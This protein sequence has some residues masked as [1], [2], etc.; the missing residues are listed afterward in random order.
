[1]NANSDE[2]VKLS[3]LLL[4]AD[5]WG[6]A[7]GFSVKLC[8]VASD[9]LLKRRG[10]PR[11]ANDDL[12]AVEHEAADVVALVIGLFKSAFFFGDMMGLNRRQM[13]TVLCRAL[14]NHYPP[15]RAAEVPR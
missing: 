4:S 8:D 2:F 10:R 5:V 11:C 1:M 13:V 6:R 9:L 15:S 14:D 12:D 3:T 7:V